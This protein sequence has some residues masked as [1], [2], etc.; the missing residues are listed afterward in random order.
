[1]ASETEK[2][3][4][5]ILKLLK[6]NSVTRI[7]LHGKRGV[8]KTWTARE[9]SKLAMKENLIHRTLWVYLNKKYSRTTLYENIACQLSLLSTEEWEDD[10]EDEM[11]E[12]LEN[13]KLRISTTLKEEA[14]EKHKKLGSATSQQERFFLLILDDVCVKRDK[15]SLFYDLNTLLGPNE[16]NFYK[17]LITTEESPDQLD[18]EGMKKEIENDNTKLYKIN[19]L[20]RNKSLTLLEER[21]MESIRFSPR[22]EHLSSAVMEISEDIPAIIITIAEVLNY[23]GRDGSWAC[24]SE[25]ILDEAGHNGKEAACI[26]RLLCCWYD[27][28]PKNIMI[29]C[30]WHGMQYFLRHGGV[31]YNELITHWIIEGYFGCY[32]QIQKAYEQGHDV[33]MDLIDCGMLRKKDDNM[34]IMEQPFFSLSHHRC[35][36]FNGTASLGLAN[37]FEDDEWEGF[38]RIT[39]AD[40][41]IKSLCG[42]KNWAKV[43]TLLMDGSCLSREVPETFFQPMQGLQV[44]AIF[45]PRFR[46]LPLL[47]PTMGKLTVLVLR[48]CDLLENIDDIHELANLHVLEISGAASMN[49]IP[50]GLFEKLLKLRGLNLSEAKIKSLPPSLCNLSQLRWLVLRQCSH[51]ETLPSLKELPN[52]EVIDLSGAVSLKSIK[53]KNFP[54]LKKLQMLDLSKSKIDR[55]PFLHSLENLTGLLL[56][57]CE[58]LTRLPSLK[59]LPSLQI[60]NVSGARDLKEMKD[61]SLENK[62]GLQILDLSGTAINQ[63][64]S[65][66]SSLSYLHLR[67]CSL[68]VKLSCTEALK[69]LKVLDLSGASAL[70]E[71]EDKSLNHLRLLQILDFSKSKIKELPSLS[72]LVNL[73]KLLL[74]DCSS[75]QKL[76]ELEGLKRL[77]MLNLSGCVEL[78]ELPRLSSLENLET[79]DLSGCR[80]LTVIDAES[81]EKMSHLQILDLSETKI[82]FLPSLCGRNRLRH[83]LLTKCVD[84]KSLPPPECLLELEVLNLCGATS[85]DKFDAQ[86]LEDMSHLRILDLSET[87]LAEL[88]SLSKL[89][90]LRQLNLRGCSHLK[91]VPQ[92]EALTKLEVIDLSGTKVDRLPS[93]NSY[94][95]LRQLLLKDCLDLAELQFQNPLSHLEVLD[96]SG[97]K[98]NKFPYEILKSTSLKRLDLPDLNGIHELDWG[99]IKHLPE[100][101]NWHQ[102][103]IFEHANNIVESKKPT[104][105]V[106]GTKIFQCLEKNPKLWETS[107]K[108]FHFFVGP[109]TKQG[110]DG[111]INF[112]KDEGIFRD[113]YFCTRYLEGYDRILEVHGSYSF[114]HGF[115][116][117]LKHTTSLSLVDNKCLSCLSNLGGG[118]VGALKGCW[119]EK[120]TKMESILCGKEVDITLGR[121]LEILWVS[122]LPVLKNLCG[123]DMQTEGFKNLK[124][125]YL[126]CC[127]VIVNVFSSSQFPENLEILHVK[128]CDKLKTLF[129]CG[130]GE[131][132][133]RTLQK[134]HTLHLLELPE[135]RSIGMQI[136]PQTDFK[137]RE[138]PNLVLQCR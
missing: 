128:F 47:S 40:G 25:T 6:D 1:M 45:N 63:L 90:N 126:D 106:R 95:N 59:T 102:C 18:A 66:I 135:L 89:T 30:F 118:N 132:E 115:E 101:I 94:S 38:G 121:N 67:D 33:L 80:A 107:F 61:D 27:M 51:L 11:E 88:P 43:S 73:R 57:G 81:F 122:N 15:E 129:E 125:L 28:L 55:L 9:T 98:I 112:W 117:V 5:D 53:D 85:L 110:E 111:Y 4:E 83:L 50:S 78:V 20:S 109:V 41:M 138:C 97:T 70:V 99:K 75:L 114:P 2:R 119:I 84:L 116:S 131:E 76:P 113:V 133:R 104:I 96:L 69:D 52:L 87:L 58:C 23:I 62:V 86:F 8:G 17:V 127:P 13:L 77:E 14:S 24:S 64:P 130:T 74:I 137:H 3:S 100:E 36:G 79:L 91:T 71:I 123:G 46:S 16:H 136:A 31:H 82:E 68:L 60:L 93:L 65:N 124:H 48:G 92:M 21:I 19:P 35:S 49:V 32:D 7:I 44:F 26:T 134:L 72:N 34:V 29:D 56:S 108:Q 37:V 120:C 105:F 103:G 39:Q 54:P 10:E 22:F 12:S 42:G